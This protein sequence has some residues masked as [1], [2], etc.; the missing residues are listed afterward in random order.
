MLKKFGV[1]AVFL[2]LLTSA[3]SGSEF[4]DAQALVKKKYPE[5]FAG[6]Q[7]L[8]ATDMAA[9]QK[10][11]SELARRGNIPL[12]R[13]RSSFSPGMNGRDGRRFG[14]RGGRSGMMRGGQMNFLRRFVAESQIK[15][16]FASEYEAA[17]KELLTAVEKIETL[18]RQ[19]KVTLPL[20]YE[21]QL[22]KLRAKDPEAFTRLEEI[23]DK[24][25]RQV[26]SGLQ[27]LSEKHNIPLREQRTDRNDAP[28]AA[29]PAAPIRENPAQT[30]RRLRRKYPAE[31]KEIMALREEN[32]KE[33]TRR[34]QEL[35]R[36]DRAAAGKK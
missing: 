10:K 30:M 24:D 11:L 22:R 34:L 6:I 15:S 27:S 5:E 17:N 9:A 28:R 1:A 12:P 8:A 4:S 33:F 7:A 26:F 36:K 31:M 2:S 14:G 3:V 13:E 18:A 29:A 23:S 19:A 21:L 20:S 25:F 35:N 16:K 32:P